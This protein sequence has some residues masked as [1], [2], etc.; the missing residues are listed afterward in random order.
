MFGTNNITLKRKGPAAHS[1]KV[2][3]H[4]AHTEFFLVYL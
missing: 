4:K 3:Y 2:Q 1:P